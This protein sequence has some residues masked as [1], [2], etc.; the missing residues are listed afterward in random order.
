MTA[1]TDTPRLV[2]RGA[3]NAGA[4]TRAVADADALAAALADGYR[5]TRVPDAPPAAGADTPTTATL[6]AGTVVAA[7]AANAP[8]G[9]A[10]KRTRRQ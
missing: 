6:V 7:D 2:Y 5:L 3:A 10:P 8:D 4:E 1:P 9:A